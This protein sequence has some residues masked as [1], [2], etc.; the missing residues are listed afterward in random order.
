MQ[1][2]VLEILPKFINGQ[3]LPN[4][5]EYLTNSTQ[6][7]IFGMSGGG[8]V[9]G[10]ADSSFA[11]GRY[12][13]MNEGGFGVMLGNP[14]NL[15]VYRG[16]N[17]EYQELKSGIQ[18]DYSQR[19]NFSLHAEII[20]KE[21][22]KDLFG[23]TPYFY[24]CKDF[25]VHGHKLSIDLEAIAQHYGFVT[26]YI[27]ISHKLFVAMF[28]AYTYCEN[29]RYYVVQDFE[30]Y[31]PVLYIAYMGR[32]FDSDP[33]AI[34]PIGFQA[35]RRP[36]AQSAM[37]LSSDD[38]SYF[39]NVAT[40]IELPCDKDFAQGIY[41][42]CMNGQVLFPVGDI[43]ADLAERVSG[44]KELLRGYVEKYCDENGLNFDDVKNDMVV[45]GY[46]VENKVNVLYEP[47]E[48]G[49]LLALA[50]QDINTNIIP[51]FQRFEAWVINSPRT[52]GL[53]YKPM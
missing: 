12:I 30:K 28:F 43:V 49:Y 5:R 1:Q 48:W 51:I 23:K 13:E 27:D 47:E 8:G 26:N 22:F 41:D 31:K 6:D 24:R 3:H 34:Q 15:C 50:D 16:E 53:S 19:K 33:L 52:C 37:A 44:T 17:K 2:S 42:S 45:N 38:Y 20:K 18:R 4:L 9:G 39:R 35:V 40:K 21:I 25:D 46:R 32:L 10:D 11:L 36:F 14:H 7:S 29:G